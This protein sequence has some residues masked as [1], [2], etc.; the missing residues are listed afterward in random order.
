MK[1][2]SSIIFIF[3]LVFAD[4]VLIR[5]P[6]QMRPMANGDKKINPHFRLGKGKA[7]HPRF[8]KPFFHPRFDPTPKN[9]QEERKDP[10]ELT[11]QQREEMVKKIED[12]LDKIAPNPEDQLMIFNQK[13]KESNVPADIKLQ[14]RDHIQQRIQQAQQQKEQSELQENKDLIFKIS[15]GSFI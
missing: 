1:S 7:P 9:S 5:K 2:L 11:Q 4:A 14:V 10:R 15:I 8:D 12:Y 13:Q 3:A 6:P